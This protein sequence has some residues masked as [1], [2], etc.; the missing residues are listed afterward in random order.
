MHPASLLDSLNG[1]S[2]YPSG[3]WLRKSEDPSCCH[4]GL[5]PES[6]PYCHPV[7][8]MR[9][10]EPAPYPGWES[11]AGSDPGESS[12]VNLPLDGLILDWCKDGDKSYFF[13]QSFICPFPSACKISKYNM[14]HHES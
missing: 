11:G 12:I 3:F 5:D 1:V 14:D 7:Q 8:A 4:S 13:L 2:Q 10:F 6:N 9:D